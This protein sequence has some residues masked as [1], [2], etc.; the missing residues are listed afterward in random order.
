VKTWTI[1][2]RGTLESTRKINGTGL[3]GTVD[4]RATSA[5]EALDK[6]N[7]IFNKP[8]VA[9]TSIVSEE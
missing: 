1:K 6:F 7:A 2:F 5:E 4:V 3:N 8:M 9:I